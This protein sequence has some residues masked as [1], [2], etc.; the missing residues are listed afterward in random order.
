MN[1]FLCLLSDGERGHGD[2]G[3]AAA[4]GGLLVPLAATT[5][6]GS[7]GRA[8][9]GRCSRCGRE[10][11]LAKQLLACELLGSALSMTTQQVAVASAAEGSSARQLTAAASEKIKGVAE[12]VLAEPG[13]SP[14]DDT[15][16]KPPGG[17]PPERPI[18]C[19]E[20]HLRKAHKEFSKAQRK[21]KSNGRCM[22][23]ITS[24][25][26]RPAH[27]PKNQQQQPRIPAQSGESTAP[28]AAGG[29]ALIRAVSPEECYKALV[30]A[31]A[32]AD[33]NGPNGGATPY[34]KPGQSLSTQPR[35]RQ[36]KKQQKKGGGKRRL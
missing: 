29:A 6:P 20:C 9:K 15:E 19:A 27:L 21:K 17:N 2:A 28:P 26:A 12:V 33:G 22:M 36:E 10:Q 8:A 35:R 7:A 16:M 13:E 11:P 34:P 1:G 3:Q 5:S 24:N 14:P 32:V 4:C 23:C 18:Q 31:L 25:P 30:D